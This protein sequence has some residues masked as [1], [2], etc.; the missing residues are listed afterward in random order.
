MLSP[1]VGFVVGTTVGFAIAPH[2]IGVPPLL[3]ALGL[4][5]GLGCAAST[6]VSERRRRSP[7]VRRSRA[8]AAPARSEPAVRAPSG[9][10]VL[11]DDEWIVPPG[12]YPDPSGLQPARYWD[13]AAWTEQ[14]EESLSDPAPAE[15]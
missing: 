9:D 6:R 12:W 3:G 11:P 15:Y 1:A 7:P 4:L 2:R 13:G 14:V 8:A 10:S 5:L